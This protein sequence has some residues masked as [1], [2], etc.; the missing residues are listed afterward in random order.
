MILK[1]NYSAEERIHILRWCGETLSLY[2]E[3]VEKHGMTSDIAQAKTLL[4]IQESLNTEVEEACCP[5]GAERHMRSLTM[6]SDESLEG[7]CLDC[8]CRKASH[9]KVWPG[10]RG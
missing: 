7:L 1:K 5:H 9:T 2:I 3:N 6:S 10:Y 8:N 4:E